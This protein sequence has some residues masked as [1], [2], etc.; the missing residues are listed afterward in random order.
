LHIHPIL[1]GPEV[2]E[3]GDND[4]Q[5]PSSYSIVFA[6]LVPRTIAIYG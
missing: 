3:H 5:L 1:P 4:P 2:Q 6:L